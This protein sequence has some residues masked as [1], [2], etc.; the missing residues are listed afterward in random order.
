MAKRKKQGPFALIQAQLRAIDEELRNHLSAHDQMAEQ[1]EGLD[2]R[3]ADVEQLAHFPFTLTFWLTLA[4]VIMASMGHVIPGAF[5]LLTAG[6]GGL[7]I[8]WA[9]RSKRLGR[10]T[11]DVRVLFTWTPPDR[12]ELGGFVG[13]APQAVAGIAL[14]L[15]A[16]LV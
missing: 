7:G 3:L 1:M 8:V 9:H 15:A 10:F 2:K 5:L 12:Y 13:H 6:L 14:L 4:G 16:L 11:S